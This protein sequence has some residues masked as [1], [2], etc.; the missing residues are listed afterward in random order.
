MIQES[1]APD[2][3]A[4]GP[5]TVVLTSHP[6]DGPASRR[7]DVLFH[8]LRKRANLENEANWMSATTAQEELLTL[9]VSRLPGSRPTD[10]IDPRLRPQLVKALGDGR[11]AWPALRL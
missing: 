4:T 10:A 5:D 2:Q 1:A 11:A 7:T 9:F 3:H 8:D 6:A